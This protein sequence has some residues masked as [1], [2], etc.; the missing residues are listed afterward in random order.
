MPE[1]SYWAIQDLDTNE[2]IIDFDTTYTKLSCDPSGSYFD[3]Y[4]SGLQPQ[5]YYKVLIKTEL[6]GSTIIF[7]DQYYFKVING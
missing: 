1:N 4:M 2:Y 3:L 6:D 5:R 7:D